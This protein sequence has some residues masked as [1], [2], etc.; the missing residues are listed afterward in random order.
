MDTVN[1]KWLFFDMGSTLLDETESYKGWF[2]NASAAIGGA[3]SPQEIEREYC[4]GMERGN[5]TVQGQLKAYGF[6]SK[7]TGSLYP[8]DLDTPYPEAGRVLKQL[9]KRYKLGIIA[10]QNPGSEARL[11]QYGLRCFFDVIAASAEICFKKPQPQIFEYALSKAGCTAEQAVMIGDRLDNDIFPAK[12]MGF[13]TVR[14]LQGYG[15]LQ[16]PRSAAYESDY[17]IQSLSQLL[18]IF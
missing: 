16:T 18:D 11:E 13:T 9:A 1:I 14:I 6:S 17:T 8:S 10:N 12:Q 15:K 2:R 5:P 3:L 4:A 7:P